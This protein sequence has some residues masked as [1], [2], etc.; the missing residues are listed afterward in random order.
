[1]KIAIDYRLAGYS[2]RGMAKYCKN[3][4]AELLKMP[5]FTKNDILFYIDKRTNMEFVPKNAKYRV[6]PTRN[7]AVGKQ[8]LLPF[9]LKKDK[10]NCLRS[11]H[12]T[13]PLFA[14]KSVNIYAT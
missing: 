10:I 8:I 6:L 11:L 3:I 2:M 4:C 12:N 1:M 5:E 9:Y 13:F 7:F 14:P